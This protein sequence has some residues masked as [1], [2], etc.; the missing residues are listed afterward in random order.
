VSL[1]RYGTGRDGCR[2]GP[3]DQGRLLP[4][5]DSGDHLHPSDAGYRAMA[6]AVDITSSGNAGA[7]GGPRIV[8]GRG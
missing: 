6:D 3:F 1:N 7:P 5:Y 4:R 8:G 2:R